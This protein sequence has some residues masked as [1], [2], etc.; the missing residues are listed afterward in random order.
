MDSLPRGRGGGPF[1]DFDSYWEDLNRRVYQ[2]KEELEGTERLFY[3]LSIVRGDL[4]TEGFEAYFEFQYEHFDEDQQYLE[5]NGFGA[6]AQALREARKL[7]FGEQAL[8]HDTVY[9]V[10]TDLY[11]EE[12]EP[13]EL[14]GQLEEMMDD[15]LPRL[16][17][18]QEFRDQLGLRE[19]YYRKL[20]W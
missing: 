4:Y 14:A 11:D 15:L 2:E 8:T 13:G 5:A 3:R 16:D 10:L 20:D 18:V 9:A 6:V 12:G 7:M 19:G 17:E 1:Y